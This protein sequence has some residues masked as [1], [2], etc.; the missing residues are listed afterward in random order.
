MKSFLKLPLF[1]IAVLVSLVWAEDISITT[2]DLPNA[3]VGKE[4]N[5]SIQADNYVFWSITEGALPPGLRR[6]DACYNRDT[7][8]CRI[9]GTPTKSGSYTFTVT[10]RSRSAE[11]TKEFTIIVELP[12]GTKPNISDRE[13][14]KENL[15][16]GEMAYLW[17]YA[18]QNVEWNVS[19]GSLPD[20]LEFYSGNASISGTPTKEGI[21]TFTI[22]AATKGGS[23]TKDFTIKVVQPQEPPYI[24]WDP[25]PEAEID[26]WF[27]WQIYASKSATWSISGD[28]PPG[29]DSRCDEIS[30]YCTIH[31]NPTQA[32]SFTFTVKTT[33]IVDSDTKDFT[34]TV[35]SQKEPT[36]ITMSLPNAQTGIRYSE[37]IESASGN[38]DWEIEGDLPPGLDLYA[39]P[40]SRYCAIQGYPTELG[41]FTFKVKTTNSKGNDSKQFTIVVEKS[42]EFEL[43]KAAAK[44]ITLPFS[45]T[46]ELTENSLIYNGGPVDAYKV[47]LRG[48]NVRISSIYGTYVRVLNQDGAIVTDFS[49]TTGTY[50]ILVIGYLGLAYELTI[51]VQ[52]V[53]T[54]ENLPDGE[55]GASYQASLKADQPVTWEIAGGYFPDGLTLSENGNIS[56][57][58]TQDGDF[59][60]LVFATNSYGDYGYKYM[61][62]SIAPEQLPT[63]TASTLPKGYVGEPYAARLTSASLSAVWSSSSLPAGLTLSASGNISGTPTAATAATGSTFTVK[64]TNNQGEDE[65]IFT[66]VIEMPPAPVI[67]TTSLPNGKVGSNYA[68]SLIG[69]RQYYTW[70][71]E[72]GSSLPEGLTLSTIGIISGNPTK[73]GSFEFT[74][75]ATNATSS[76]TK[77]LTIIVDAATPVISAAMPKANLKAWMHNGSLYLSG[78]TAGKSWSIY[79]AKGTL[80][81]SG[82]ANN[83]EMN[84]K[85][86]LANGIYFVKTNGQTLRFINK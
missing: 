52:P 67:S 20:G 31:G 1:A 56:G 60:F 74:V 45:T 49:G 43:V 22:T 86:N 80:L 73:E 30:R 6:D 48:Q 17:I 53:I 3:Q 32:G 47:D 35:A 54:T 2:S 70:S 62:I 44:T 42:Q 59:E 5:K 36:I 85:L 83:V 33:N 38:T 14:Y 68:A 61:T 23:T 34:I 24:S 72:S 12:D 26:V 28:L 16:V 81:H 4:Y 25:M 64:A 50:Y 9:L 57:K 18:D 76:S 10:A 82:T 15:E 63:I 27:D 65:A 69:E 41:S 29:L 58:P 40:A 37:N 46:G 55:V 66:I 77:T 84:V 51:S 11:S 21:Y 75:K 19:A 79:S 13:E 7:Y 71:L 78:L 39:R 8:I